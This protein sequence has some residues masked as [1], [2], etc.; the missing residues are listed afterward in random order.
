MPFFKLYWFLWRIGYR[1]S[2]L[3]AAGL[4]TH[5]SAVNLNCG[6]VKSELNLGT[7][8]QL[9]GTLCSIEPLDNALCS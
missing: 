8:K 2:I 5:A 3:P 4:A 1:L 7:L 6:W 9:V